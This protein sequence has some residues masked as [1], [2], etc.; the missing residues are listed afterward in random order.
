[1]HKTVAFRLLKTL[2]DGR[3]VEQ[4]A[5][6]GRFQIGLGAFEVAQAYPHATSL[7]GLSRRYLR[8]LVEGSPHTAYLASLD[9]FDIVYL[10]SV[11]GTGPL[12]VHVNPGS[13]NPAYA[14]AVGKVLLAELSDE[15]IAQLA[16]RA[17]F[18][19]VAPNTI[20]STDRLLGSVREVRQQGYAL[21]S[22]E[23]YPGIGAVA[24]VI[25]DAF[26][27]AVAGICVS[28]ATSLLGTGELAPW[29][30]RT[31]TTAREISA[32]LGAGAADGRF[33]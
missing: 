6:T 1:L 3:F 21:N 10:D 7:I 14:T 13:R 2:A 19:Q 4:D 30:D 15:E 31:T 32:A 18:A 33:A 11:E 20:T 12:R 23:A 25:R 8:A 27:K 28:Y 24:A 17:A 9:G 16:E 22:E 29:I 5:D 26:G